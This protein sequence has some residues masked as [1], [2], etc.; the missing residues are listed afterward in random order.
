MHTFRKAALAV[1]AVA[2]FA[3]AG[4]G[5]AVP[6][7]SASTTLTATTHLTNRQDG[8]HN[9]LGAPY[10]ATDTMT[11]VA[12]LVDNG[13]D[14]NRSGYDTFSFSLSDTGTFVT[15]NNVGNPN[16]LN[17]T[18]PITGTV[19]GTI[20]G[21]GTWTTF[22]APT[23]S[24]DAGLV[25]KSL[26][27]NG[28]AS[29][30]WPGL[31]FPQGTNFECPGPQLT[32]YTTAIQPFPPNGCGSE[33]TYNYTYKSCSEQWVDSNTDNDGDATGQSPA[34]Q[35]II[36]GI[37]GVPCPS[38]RPSPSHHKPPHGFP[39]GGVETGGGVPTSGSWVPLIAVLA[40][41]GALMVSGFGIARLRRQ[42]G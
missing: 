2:A 21:S 24:A 16:G 40:S 15:N 22:D 3:A 30:L 9:T 19:T 36:G 10:W 32:A 17:P 5:L 38:P 29:Y 35:A 6:A 14:P 31:F 18:T 1:S 13:P 7:A 42:R 23:G 26:S 4:L 41:L 27:G 33:D 25:P 37:S 34:E 8:G 11:R 20:K 39:V 12:T 28:T